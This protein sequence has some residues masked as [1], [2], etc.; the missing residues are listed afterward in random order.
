MADL[1]RGADSFRMLNGGVVECL[2]FDDGCD[3]IGDLISFFADL[4]GICEIML[5]ILD[6]IPHT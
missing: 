3:F 6:S 5:Y 2:Y 1:G 4:F